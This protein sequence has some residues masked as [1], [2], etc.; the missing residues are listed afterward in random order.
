MSIYGTYIQEAYN[1]NKEESVNEGII[2]GALA[3]VGAFFLANIAIVAL[4]L[5]SAAYNSMQASKIREKINSNSKLKALLTKA[6][7]NLAKFFVANLPG[8]LRKY[9]KV[10]DRIS[11]VSNKVGKEK[12]KKTKMEKL[13]FPFVELDIDKMFKDVYH[14]NILDYFYDKYKDTYSSND[15]SEEEIKQDMLENS[16]LYEE[17]DNFPELK[18]K[19][20]SINEI[21]DKINS[22]TSSVVKNCVIKIEKLDLEFE[23]GAIQPAVHSGEVCPLFMQIL[24]RDF[25]NVKFS[26]EEKK[27]LEKLTGEKFD[28]D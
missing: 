25:N 20:L 3:A 1:K 5:L 27:E 22:K 21:I 26:D 24:S 17:I 18:K 14:K 7:E 6:A 13:D 23:F 16:N 9:F 12:V 19:L 8:D 2:T 28:K 4:L 10:C 15:E 11:I